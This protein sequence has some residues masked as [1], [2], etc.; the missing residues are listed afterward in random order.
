MACKVLGPVIH[1]SRE[2]CLGWG[3]SETRVTGLLF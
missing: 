2:T 1:D 3:L